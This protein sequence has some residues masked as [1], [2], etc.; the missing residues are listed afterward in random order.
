MDELTS[1]AL[2][3]LRAERLAGLTADPDAPPFFGRIDRSD[4]A[5]G[6]ESFHIGR[7]HLR[8]PV[9]RSGRAGLAGAAVRGLLPSR[10]PG[11]DGPHPASAVRVPPR[12]TEFLRGRA[13]RPRRVPG[14][15]LR[16]AAGRD[17]APPPGPDARHRRHHPA[18][19]GRA[20]ARRPR[21]VA[22]RPGRAG[23]GQDGGRPAPRCIPALHLPAAPAPHRRARHRPEPGLPALHRSG[24]ALTR[25]G[26]HRADHRRRPAGSTDRHGPTVDTVDESP[27]LATLKGDRRLAEV[28][29]RAVLSHVRKPE[30]DVVALVGTKRY[31]ISAHDLRRV[32]DDTRRSLTD[33]L[34][35]STGRDRIR[36]QVAETG[37]AHAR[38]RRWRSHRRG[39]DAPGPFA[40]GAR[41]RRRGVARTDRRSPAGPALGRARVPGAMRPGVVDRRRT[42]RPA[43]RP[44]PGEVSHPVER[45][46]RRSARR[47]ALPARRVRQLRPRRAGR[48]A[49]PVAHAVARGRTTLRAGLDHRCSATWPRPPPPGAR[50]T[51]PPPWMPWASRPGCGR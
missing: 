31:R 39:D 30:Q 38:G 17:R 50:A 19:P 24:V 22:V 14:V 13:P 8:D 5:T 32:V 43:P 2:G 18:R 51:G 45:G 35:W 36:V 23:H 47:T 34:H 46:R 25:R 6:R 16:P 12:R 44:G 11:P 21:H 15:G 42:R 33:G 48:G 9:G 26:G 10:P 29:R 28:L 7:R 41:V 49:G 20:R 40:T 3:R 37:P 4:P 1:F 27:A